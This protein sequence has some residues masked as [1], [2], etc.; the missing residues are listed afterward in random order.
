MT[1]NKSEKYRRASLAQ[2]TPEQLATARRNYQYCARR[3]PEEQGKIA[4]MIEDRGL[5]DHREVLEHY[6]R[7]KSPISEYELGLIGLY[8]DTSYQ[9]AHGKGRQYYAPSTNRPSL[10]SR[11]EEHTSELPSLMRNSYTVY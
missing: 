7:N 8:G 9:G 2:L 3:F 4:A 10:V 11:S 6:A 1:M 5:G